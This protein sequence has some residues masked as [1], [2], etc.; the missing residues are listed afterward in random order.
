MALDK[1]HF[2]WYVDLFGT[3]KISE[4]G[5]FNSEGY[6]GAICVVAEGNSISADSFSNEEQCIFF[7]NEISK[8]K[9][10]KIVIAERQNE[11][12]TH[13]SVN[14]HKIYT[15]ETKTRVKTAGKQYEIDWLNIVFYVESNIFDYVKSFSISNESIAYKLSLSGEKIYEDITKEFGNQIESNCW[16]NAPYFD[17]RMLKNVN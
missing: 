6:G 14:L 1:I 3:A 2:D 13:I 7:K 4:V 12:Q 16:I 10:I 17:L 8:Q 15:D 5:Y 9:K 11:K